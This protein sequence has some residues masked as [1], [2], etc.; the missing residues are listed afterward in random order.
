MQRRTSRE[1]ALC[2]SFI[3]HTVALCDAPGRPPLSEQPSP[4]V[5]PELHVNPSAAFI[6]AHGS[7]A[8]SPA[9]TLG[10]RQEGPELELDV[11]RQLTAVLR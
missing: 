7:M 10:P 9:F 6:P 4:P 2:T 3:I 11:G 1:E 5:A 8:A